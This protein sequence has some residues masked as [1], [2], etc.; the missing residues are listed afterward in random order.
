MSSATPT[1]G[2]SLKELSNPFL[3]DWNKKVLLLKDCARRMFSYA[4]EHFQMVVDRYKIEVDRVQNDIE[5]AEKVQAIL[6]RFL[7]NLSDDQMPQVKTQL[8]QEIGE[9]NFTIGL[10][11]IFTTGECVGRAKKLTPSLEMWR[12]MVQI[13]KD[14]NSQE[15]FRDVMEIA[16]TFGDVRGT[17]EVLH[18]VSVAAVKLKRPHVAIEAASLNVNAELRDPIF[19]GIST[20]LARQEPFKEASLDL[21]VNVALRIRDQLQQSEALKVA[22]LVLNKNGRTAK[23]DQAVR[24][25]PVDDIR[26]A[27]QMEIRGNKVESDGCSIF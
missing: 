7:L 27:A 8:Q 21:S 3:P 25:I 20:M 11:E 22:G 26:E 18:W 23:S 16:L 9:A 14:L 12:S 17:A 4:Q 13:C 5:G 19:F 15:R 24:S 6:I 1:L 10:K 2:T